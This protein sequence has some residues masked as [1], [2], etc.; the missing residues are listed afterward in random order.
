MK[1]LLLTALSLASLAAALPAQSAG[2][3]PRAAGLR[4]AAE[5]HGKKCVVT[6][7]EGNGVRL[8]DG[9]FDKAENGWLVLQVGTAGRL[10]IA[11]DQ[12]VA[13]SFENAP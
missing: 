4:E 8:L 11:L 7:R 6:V 10:L 12:I 3:D 13:I 1:S 2:P 9:K 5:K